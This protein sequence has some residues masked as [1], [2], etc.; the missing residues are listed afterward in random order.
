MN[1]NYSS[2][3]HSRSWS[4]HLP[5]FGLHHL[6]PA[7]KG[8]QLNC[9]AWVKLTTDRVYSNTGSLDCGC[10]AK[11]GFYQPLRPYQFRLLVLYSGKDGDA[12][13]GELVTYSLMDAPE[14]AAVSY[15]WGDSTASGIVQLSGVQVPV[16][17]NLEQCLY[18]QRSETGPVRLWIDSV[19][20]NQEDF[21]EKSLQVSYMDRIYGSARS[22]KVWLGEE[23][24]HSSVGMRTLEYFSKHSR[25]KKDAP[26]QKL[27]PEIVFKGLWDVMNRTWFRRMWV[28]QEVVLS[29]STELICGSCS[30]SW[31]ANDPIGV[32]HFQRMIKYAGIHPQWRL[33]G[34]ADID[35]HPLLELLEL[36]LGQQLDRSFG[37]SLRPAR[38]ILDVAY[39][40][41]R[42][43][44]S[45]PRDM[46]F[47][48]DGMAKNMWSGEDLQPNYSLTVE[49][50]YEHLES[51]IKW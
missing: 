33:Q 27:P 1:I 36:Q 11:T 42:R 19:C 49:Q 10:Y 38:D 31:C 32:R 25:P 22:V 37:T 47:A 40:L 14:Y 34:L 18:R 43:L 30:F 16:T 3:L 51:V 7:L 13:H 20:I 46:I 28:V 4:L 29:R 17:H 24:E 6:F 9:G 50:T 23:S 41:R 5:T 45:D 26:W 2:S 48:L 12:L 39:D 21:A 44:S 15:S 8:L 35:M